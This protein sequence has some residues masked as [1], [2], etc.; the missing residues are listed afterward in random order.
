MSL[1]LS[2][3]V[4]FILLLP[5]IAFRRLYYSEE[6]SQQYFRE[7]LFLVFTATIVPSLM[8]Q[9]VW[10]WLGQLFTPAPSL[11]A[12]GE[13]VSGDSVTAALAGVEN[14]LR[15][16]VLHQ[17]S[18][19]LL[20]G[21]TGF[22]ARKVVRSRK[23]DRRYKLFRYRNNWHYTLKG[24]F[25]DF[26]RAEYNLERDT[27]EDIEL[28]SVNAVQD[29]AA[30]S[31]L[32]MGLLVDYELAADG[33][34]KTISLKAVRRRPLTQDAPP[35]DPHVDRFYRIKGHMMVLKY[36]ELKNL[37]LTYLKLVEGENGYRSPVEVY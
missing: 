25:F 2:T 5:G 10:Y 16:I 34:L 6:F 13:L 12:L 20:A 19:C 27:V 17:G 11:S 1:A 24:E 7:N 33:G 3:V 23:W 4:L 37:N 30:G 21:L 9:L 15:W 28:V 29:T 22:A 35:S 26:P 31:Y 32:Y 14:D 18:L 36:D 8:F